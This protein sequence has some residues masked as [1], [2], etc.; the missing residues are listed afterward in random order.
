MTGL[1]AA[2]GRQE[3]GQELAEQVA[4]LPLPLGRESSPDARSI[5]RRGKYDRQGRGGTP[6][7]AVAGMGSLRVARSDAVGTTRPAQAAR[8]GRS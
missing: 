6:R 8:R 5:R 4:E 1:P 3:P 2:I 7:R